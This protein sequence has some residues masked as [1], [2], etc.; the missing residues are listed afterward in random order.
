MRHIVGRYASLR[1]LDPV[2]TVDRVFA[3]LERFERNRERRHRIKKFF[4]KD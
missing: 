2:K 4:K 1:G 3:M